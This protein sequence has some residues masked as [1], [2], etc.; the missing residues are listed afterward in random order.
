LIEKI[1]R[2]TLLVNKARC[3]ANIRKMKLKAELSHTHFR[4]HF[5]THQSLQVAEWFRQEGIQSITVSSVSMALAFAKNGWHDITIAFPFNI[6]ETEDINHLFPGTTI[7]LLVESQETAGFLSSNL[8][9]NVRIFMEIDTGYHRSGISWDDHKGIREIIR[10]CRQS[11]KLEFEGFL[12]HSGHTYRAGSPQEIHDIYNDTLEKMLSL[13]QQFGNDLMISVGDTPS[14]SL[15]NSFPGIDEIRPGNFVYYD[16][17]QYF[18]GVCHMDEIAVSVACPVVAK[19]PSRKE[20]VIYGG[21]VHLSKEGLG[22]PD[23]RIIYGKVLETNLMNLPEAENTGYIISLS[24]E[25]G[26]ISACR[27]FID[28]I[29]IGDIVRIIPVHSCLTADLL[30]GNTMITI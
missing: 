26:I 15:E 13:K 9:R 29:A 24:Q 5:K 27:E 12:I 16:L 4:P 20:V 3:L 17:M 25:H 23:G 18:L 7:G 1:K 11:E 22:L 28:K 21:A 19:Y 10:I 2:P 6:R 8:R 30:K 14:C